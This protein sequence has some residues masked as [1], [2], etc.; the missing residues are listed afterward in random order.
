MRGGERR[1]TAWK[2][3]RRDSTTIEFKKLASMSAI[4]AAPTA[5]PVM[6]QEAGAGWDADGDGA[7]G[8]SELAEGF[9]ERDNFD[10]WDQDSDGLL[11]DN[12][13]SEGVYG[14]YDADVSGGLED[15]E[16]GMAEKGVGAAGFWATKTSA[17]T[18]RPGMS[19][20]T[21]SSCPTN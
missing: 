12:E 19:T 4:L 5:A 7:L 16:Y 8:E 11:S 2:R 17:T 6:A 10:S 18:T 15:A 1:K 20:A 21:A 9:A 14:T 13:F 3:H